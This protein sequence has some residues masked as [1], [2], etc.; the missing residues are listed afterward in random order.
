M[1]TRYDDM[2]YYGNTTL[3]IYP[4]LVHLMPEYTEYVYDGTFRNM[5]KLVD[6]PMGGADALKLVKGHTA[7]GNFSIVRGLGDPIS[8]GDVGIYTE[9]R[10]F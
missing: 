7:T 4:R 5:T 9:N 2:L 10:V 1:N 3:V 8:I 6:S